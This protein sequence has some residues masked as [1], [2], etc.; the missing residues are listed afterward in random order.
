[1]LRPPRCRS[2]FV[3][4][5]GGPVP[6]YLVWNRVRLAEAT[7]STTL[8]TAIDIFVAG[9]V[10]CIPSLG[11]LYLLHEEARWRRRDSPPW[12]SPTGVA[13]GGQ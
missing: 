1:M 8:A 12:A 4:G 3:A 7:A 11:V 10:T 13:Q 5:E 6:L 9:A 2:G